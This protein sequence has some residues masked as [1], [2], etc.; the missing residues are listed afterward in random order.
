MARP[1]L[2]TTSLLR[3]PVIYAMIAGLFFSLGAIVIIGD[4]TDKCLPVI[5]VGRHGIGQALQF[6]ALDP[7]ALDEPLQ[8]ITFPTWMAAGLA[9]GLDQ[10]QNTGVFP[11]PELV[12]D[13]NGWPVGYGGQW[14]T[15]Y[16]QTV[17][18]RVR[19]A[20]LRVR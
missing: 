8:T 14:E 20:S 3:S 19:K 9:L 4:G 15:V 5:V 2:K 18:G 1:S 10:N 16:V 17:C 13:P 6:E 7:N 12:N 11:L